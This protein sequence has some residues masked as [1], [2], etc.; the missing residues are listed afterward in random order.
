MAWSRKSRCPSGWLIWLLP[1]AGLVSLLWFLIRVVPKPSRATYP[2]QRLAAPIASGFVVWIMGLL[3]STLAYRSARRL[4][5]RSRYVLAGICVAAAVGVVWTSFC[6][7]HSKSAGAALFTP[8]EPANNPMGAAKGIHPGRVVW[9]RDPAAT[10]WD[11]S[12]GSW[13][14]DDNTDQKTVDAMVSEAI[15]QLTG[16]SSDA[17]A[18][19]S[20]FKYF[21]K[22]KGLGDVGYQKPE[23]IAI[24]INMNQDR[25]GEWKPN[26][27][28]P[29]PHV[30]YSLM[31]QL[32]NK[33]GVP[34]SAITLYDAT[35][36]IG[37]PIY[38]K[39]KSD[40]NPEFQKVSF[41]VAPDRAQDGRLAATYD[42]SHPLHT[43]AGTA[44]LPTCVTQAK[45]LI[46]L[47]LMRAHTLFGVTLC[48]K[49]HFGT[50][51]FPDG[52]GW[53]PSPLH[54]Y[55]SRKDPM[56]SYNC[57]VNLNGHRQ[58]DGKTFLY[59]IDA[60]YPSRNQSSGVIRFASFDNDWF[61][62]I[63]VSQDLVAIDSVGLDFLRN[64]QASGSNVVDVV[65]NPDN[66][67][68][69]AA[70][71]NQ[72]PSGTTYDPEADGTALDSMGVHEHWN[73]PKEMKYSRNLGTGKGLELVTK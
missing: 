67:L 63:L 9:I 12:T 20:L 48:A 43:K 42:Q 39:I 54:N 69:E 65:G 2:C 32:V 27:G 4:L 41:V 70:L 31:D 30:I 45:Y 14:D 62:S 44:Y 29:S 19:E 7:T 56:G 24:K 35:R 3:G 16:E 17:K 59:M 36:Y 34:G 61:S 37:D 28:N 8:T 38:N 26:V 1:I 6:V 25:P 58:L 23:K 13:W 21:N 47:A 55:G 53:T 51:Y 22:S 11:G 66:Y 49:N 64:E 57:L 50:M 52:R 33:A 18:W 73:N 60:L 5:Q 10:S 72:S 40:P 68:H 15:R 46:N 71:A